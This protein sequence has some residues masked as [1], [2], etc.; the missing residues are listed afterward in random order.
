MTLLS[1]I[2]PRKEVLAGELTEGLFAAGLQEVAAGTAADTYGR[3]ETFFAQT[4]PSDGLRTLLNEALGR[5]LGTRPDAASV[6]RL[7]TNFGGGKTH[8]LI[9][10]FHAA[11][12]GIPDDLVAQFMEPAVLAGTGGP[13][14]AVA[15]FVGSTAGASTF[16]ALEGVT[17]STP[18]GYL[19]LQIGGMGAYEIVRQDDET[20][21]APGSDQLKRVFGDKPVLILIDEIARYLAAAG[22]RKGSSLDRVDFG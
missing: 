10:L 6:L 18:W 11:R 17:A 21:S 20:L 13:A 1:T 15:V 9:A 4:H 5:L 12:T 14:P 2:T 16:P 3:P 8:N 7:E 19:A 22:A